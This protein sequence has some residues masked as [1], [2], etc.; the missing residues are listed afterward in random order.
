MAIA[1]QCGH[2]RRGESRYVRGP[3]GSE[4]FRQREVLER[5]EVSGQVQERRRKR[6]LRDLADDMPWIAAQYRRFIGDGAFEAS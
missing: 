1:E 3:D 2:G 5:W 4:V 6:E